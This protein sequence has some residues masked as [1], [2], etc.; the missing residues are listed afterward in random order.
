[1]LYHRLKHPF[2]VDVERTY[3]RC[4]KKHV[5]NDS[6]PSSLSVLSP[7]D[8]LLECGP[9]RIHCS[10]LALETV[11]ILENVF[12]SLA[13]ALIFLP[14]NSLHMLDAR[15]LVF[16]HDAVSDRVKIKDEDNENDAYHSNNSRHHKDDSP[17]FIVL[18]TL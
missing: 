17:V 8:C 1:M 14:V 7:A 9:T 11:L 16:S 12:D 10:A 6:D 13:R 3:A 5:E 15:L 4:Y 2:A 18:I